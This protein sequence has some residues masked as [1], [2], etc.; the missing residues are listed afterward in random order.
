[1][2]NYC[3]ALQVGIDIEKLD[4]IDIEVALE[5]VTAQDLANVLNHL[6]IGPI[7]GAFLYSGPFTPTA[8]V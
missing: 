4:I 3:E 1:M 2:E 6:L 8:P 5:E 7:A